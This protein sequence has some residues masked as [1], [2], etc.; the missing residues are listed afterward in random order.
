MRYAGIIYDDTA[1]APGLC[2]SFYTQ[3]CD[4]HCPGCHNPETW[5]FDGGH[6]FTAQ[7]IDNIISGIKRNGLTRNFAV[8]GGEPLA[9]NNL[10]LTAMVVQT[11]R[12][13]YPQIKIWIWSGYEMY[14]IM[15][16][17]SQPHLKLILQNID[18]LVTGPYIQHLRDITLPYRGSSNQEVWTLDHDKNIWYNMYDKYEETYSNV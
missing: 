15:N 9:P 16:A 6:E 8:L 17:K 10:F 11:V 2:L 12:Q 1:A 13:A 14:E 18:T 5:D 7:T 3:G 4:Q